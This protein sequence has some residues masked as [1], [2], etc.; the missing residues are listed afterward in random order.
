METRMVPAGTVLRLEQ[1]GGGG[2]GDPA[3][4]P[5]SWCCATSRTATSRRRWQPCNINA[6][7]RESRPPSISR[8]SG[9][10]SLGR[11]VQSCEP[12]MYWWQ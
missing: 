12:R 5:R 2:Y 11:S 8:K 7:F 4:R 10:C 3:Q 6:L 9:L 1:A